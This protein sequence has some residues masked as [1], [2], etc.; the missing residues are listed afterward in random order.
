MTDLHP[1]I[2]NIIIVRSFPD[3][4]VRV[5]VSFFLGVFGSCLIYVFTSFVIDLSVV[6]SFFRSLFL[7]LF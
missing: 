5:V 7:S 4:F 6:I 3:F 2:V 1:Y